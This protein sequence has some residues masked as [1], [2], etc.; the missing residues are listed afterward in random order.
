MRTLLQLAED[1]ERS[2][3]LG[4]E[5]VRKNIDVDDCHSGRDIIELAKEKALQSFKWNSCSW[6]VV[7]NYKC[8]P[9][10]NQLYFQ[11]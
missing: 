4:S 1:E 6:R 9:Q 7:L 2:L 5:T 3:C 11:Q 10:T 8:G